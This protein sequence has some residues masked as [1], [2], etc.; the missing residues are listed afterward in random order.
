MKE[1]KK[2]ERKISIKLT[3]EK[4]IFILTMCACISP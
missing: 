3:T 4:R 1:K 2:K